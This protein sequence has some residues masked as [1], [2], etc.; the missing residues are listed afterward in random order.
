MSNSKV[1]SKASTAR[2]VNLNELGNMIRC[3]T[4]DDPSLMFNDLLLAREIT[5]T[6]GKI[7]TSDDIREY[8]EIYETVNS[9]EAINGNLH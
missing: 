2:K 4:I 5:I 1:Q 9:E 7:C 8:Y 3:V 6:F